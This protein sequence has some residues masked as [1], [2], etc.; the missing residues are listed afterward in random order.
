MTGYGVDYSRILPVSVQV[1]LPAVVT[2]HSSG[3]FE[4]RIAEIYVVVMDSGFLIACIG[5]LGRSSRFCGG[6]S[7]GHV[8]MGMDVAIVVE[9]KGGGVGAVLVPVNLHDEEEA[10]YDNERGV[11]RGAESGKG[12]RVPP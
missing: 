1:R 4:V 2:M 9:G 11:R 12:L 8:L 3:L 6:S 7:C 10:P 5:G